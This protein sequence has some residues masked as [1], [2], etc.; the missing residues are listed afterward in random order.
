MWQILV[1]CDICI[2]ATN[3]FKNDKDFYSIYLCQKK[4]HLSYSIG[5]ELKRRH[6]FQS[7]K[8]RDSYNTTRSQPQQH[9]SKAG[10]RQGGNSYG[11]H[12]PATL[13]YIIAMKE[14]IHIPNYYFLCK[15]PTDNTIISYLMTAESY[16]VRQLPILWLKRHA[17][18]LK[19]GGVFGGGLGD[20]AL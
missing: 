14:I 20:E 16:S 4:Q 18:F 9:H 17:W 5:V 10:E 15:T 7:C 3:T 19:L 1:F 6:H 13:N 12:I 2:M 8:T 11:M